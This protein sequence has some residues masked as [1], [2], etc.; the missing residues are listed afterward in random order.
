MTNL[1]TALEKLKAAAKRCE[2]AILD[3]QDAS[4]ELQLAMDPDRACDVDL[5]TMVCLNEAKRP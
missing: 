4:V 1:D 3:L 5:Q 2:E